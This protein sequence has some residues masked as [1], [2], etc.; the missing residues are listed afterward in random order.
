M[1]GVGVSFLEAVDAV[2][3]LKMVLKSCN[4]DFDLDNSANLNGLPNPA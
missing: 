1:T 4:F 2:K 3:F